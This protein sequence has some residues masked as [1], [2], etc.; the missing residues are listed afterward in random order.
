MK[1]YNLTPPTVPLKP[2]TDPTKAIDVLY[3]MGRRYPYHEP[4][5]VVRHSAKAAADDKHT[6]YLPQDIQDARAPGYAND[7]GGWVRG[8]GNKNLHPYFDSGPSGR[9]Y[10]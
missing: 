10:K 7:A 9:R 1:R 5:E 2:G 4:H 3:R 6:H 8:M